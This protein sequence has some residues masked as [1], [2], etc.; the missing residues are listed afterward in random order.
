MKP[1]LCIVYVDKDALL[2][3]DLGGLP[4]ALRTCYILASCFPTAKIISVVCSEMALGILRAAG[5]SAVLWPG[6]SATPSVSDIINWIEDKQ[7][8]QGPF[9]YCEPRLPFLS[10]QTLQKA[11]QA[12]Y[13]GEELGLRAANGT[14]LP[15]FMLRSGSALVPPA[16]QVAVS[17][18]EAV[19]IQVPG[20]LCFARAIERG[21]PVASALKSRNLRAGNAFRRLQDIRLVVCDIDGVLTDGKM[22]YSENGDELKNFHTRDGIAA[23]ALKAAGYKLAILS[24]GICK[25][26]VGKRGAFLG[27]D[28]VVVTKQEKCIDLKR[29]SNELDVPL[30]HILYIGDDI[31]DEAAMT[32]CG[33]TCC[34][35][36]AWV[37]IRDTADIV[38]ET[39]G[40]SGCLRE[41]A[42]LLLES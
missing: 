12:L 36:D 17:Q 10:P 13:R 35:A 23:K 27:F 41:V 3:E 22:I 25:N 15:C 24:S 33:V 11:V 4:L 20:D 18:M 30:K 34:P 39:V 1:L 21:L 42:Q 8:P 29:L 38:L 32:L 28:A 7:G 40:G 19:T 2:M 5:F 6:A 16:Q 31:N 26:I 14:P 9:L 37:S